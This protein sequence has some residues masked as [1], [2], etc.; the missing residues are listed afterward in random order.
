LGKTE[1]L[2]GG[3]PS[4]DTWRTLFG[5][6]GGRGKTGDERWIPN[7]KG[8]EPWGKKKKRGWG[9]LLGPR[10]TFDKIGE[11]PI[12][13]GERRRGFRERWYPGQRKESLKHRGTKRGNRR[14][15][16]TESLDW[17]YM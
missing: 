15:V 7:R 14:F 8:G 12:I 9:H 5:G 11:M 2:G 16:P 6:G 17:R 13:G 10:K 1:K 4:R 3:S